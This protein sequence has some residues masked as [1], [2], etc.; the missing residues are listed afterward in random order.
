MSPGLAPRHRGLAPAEYEQ[1]VI[2]DR[3]KHRPTL[4]GAIRQGEELQQTRKPFCKPLEAGR[5]HEDSHAANFLEPKLRFKGVPQLSGRWVIDREVMARAERGF[6]A[7]GQASKGVSRL[8]PQQAGHRF[9]EAEPPHHA[10]RQSSSRPHGPRQRSSHR[11]YLSQ[12]QA[13]ER[14]KVGE[15]PIEG[16]RIELHEPFH[17]HGPRG[18]LP[19]QPLLLR[20]AARCLNHSRRNVRR[21][22]L[23]SPFSKVRRVGSCPA[24][25]IQNSIARSEQAVQTSPNRRSLQHTDLR[26]GPVPVVS[27]G[28]FVK[29]RSRP[30][31]RRDRFRGTHA[32]TSPAAVSSPWRADKMLVSSSAKS[33]ALV[34]PLPLFRNRSSVTSLFSN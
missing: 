21:K 17:P 30:I 23:D 7:A 8:Q 15:R 20:A 29:C 2:A 24:T 9:P 32:S 5:R 18:H 25:E 12:A 11:R 14:S 34:E 31:E 19:G 22:H 3:S 6:R 4:H 1:T 26:R 13:V 10:K 28:D 33:V 16:F 27:F